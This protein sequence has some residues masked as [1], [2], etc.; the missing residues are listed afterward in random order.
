MQD[1]GALE[2]I[3]LASHSQPANTALQ[4]ALVILL[5]DWNIKPQVVLGHSSGN[6]SDS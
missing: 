4:I 6:F 1:S 3:H 2:T 5:R